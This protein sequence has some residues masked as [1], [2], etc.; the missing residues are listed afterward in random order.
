MV[1]GTKELIELKWEEVGVI[2]N[3]RKIRFNSGN[4]S[5]LV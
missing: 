4:V 3:A 1:D 5:G 2:G